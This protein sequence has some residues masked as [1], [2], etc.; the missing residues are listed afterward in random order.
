MICSIHKRAAVSAEGVFV[1]ES[2]ASRPHFHTRLKVSLKYQIFSATSYNLTMSS[3]D[4][5]YPLRILTIFTFVPAFPLLLAHGIVS[6]EVVPAVGIVPLAGSAAF[7]AFLLYKEKRR[8]SDDAPVLRPSIILAVD[9]F[10]AA[11]IITVLIFTWLIVP[12]EWGRGNWVMLA[13]YGT[14]PLLANLYA[15]YIFPGYPQLGDFRV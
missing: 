15:A 12:G 9:A 2:P 8:E 10:L 14:F 3:E 13:T 11:C 1:T 5:A 6:G 7:S 4:P